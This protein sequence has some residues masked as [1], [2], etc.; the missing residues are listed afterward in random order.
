MRGNRGRAEP[1]G[2]P[3]R[4]DWQPVG[5]ELGKS[6]TAF[7]TWKTTEELGGE[8]IRKVETTISV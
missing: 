7:L 6:A 5:V 3:W 8:A 2:A 1:E 4:D